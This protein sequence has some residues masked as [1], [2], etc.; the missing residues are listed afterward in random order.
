[1]H[2]RLKKI[3]VKLPPHWLDVSKENPDGP[4][5]FINGKLDEPGVLQISVAKYV[6]GQL[7]NP[8]FEDLIS[9]SE[10]RKDSFGEIVNKFSGLCKFGRYG[11]VHFSSVQ[12]PHAQVWHL[13]NGKDFVFVTFIC[14]TQPDESELKEVY[15]IITSIEERFKFF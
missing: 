11:C 7:P 2:K 13:S 6:K 14:S 9:L 5:T 12:F 8:G 3:R 4:P 15:N 10:A 1:M